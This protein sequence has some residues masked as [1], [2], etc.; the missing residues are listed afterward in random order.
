MH[1][2][3]VDVD[4]AILLGQRRALRQEW[5]HLDRYPEIAPQWRHPEV[6]LDERLL[7]PSADLVRSGAEPG[8]AELLQIPGRSKIDAGIEIK[9]LHASPRQ[10]LGGKRPS[11]GFSCQ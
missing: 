7:A 9:N 5:E 10:V 1:Q 2:E 11:T 4:P 8:R 3:A 6:Q